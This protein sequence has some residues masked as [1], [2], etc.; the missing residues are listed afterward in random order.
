MS[1]T[2]K[3]ADAAQL[4][5]AVNTAFADYFL[6]MSY[7][8]AE[9]I[10]YRLNKNSVDYS[11]SVGAFYDESMIGFTMIGIAEYNGELAAFDAMTGIV[12]AY[13]NQGLASRMFEYALPALKAKGVQTFYLDVLQVNEAAIKA[14]AKN[15]FA[16][17][18]SFYCGEL[19]FSAFKPSSTPSGIVIR[20]AKTAIIADFE[21]DFSCNLAWE[22]SLQSMLNI[23]DKLIC[24]GA[25]SGETCVGIVVYSPSLNWILN[26]T[27]K[28]E[29]RRKGIAAALLTQLIAQLSPELNSLKITNID[30]EAPEFIQFLNNKGFENYTNQYEMKKIL[31]GT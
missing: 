17:S 28:K 22:N 8:T 29:Y 24:L 30:T 18:R 10:A 3:Q 21:S 15:G 7:M 5:E 16:I 26:L 6:N 11:V 31:G 19:K 25:F 4:P 27:V 14:Y 13:R 2:I 20:A 1:I 23:A 9:K 12:K